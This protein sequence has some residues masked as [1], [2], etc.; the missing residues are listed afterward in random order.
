[1]ARLSRCDLMVATAGVMIPQTA[2]ATDPVIPEAT[3]AARKNA[4]AIPKKVNRL[5]NLAQP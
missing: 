1:M 2:F 5:Y 4:K 3:I